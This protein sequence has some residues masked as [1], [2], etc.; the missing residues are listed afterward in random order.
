MPTGLEKVMVEVPFIKGQG[1]KSAP[2]MMEMDVPYRLHNV[3]LHKGSVPE[4]RCGH[5]AL[6]TST[7]G[8]PTFLATGIRRIVSVDDELIALTENAGTMG[9]GGGAGSSGDTV[10]AYAE[11]AD[12]WR[13]FGKIQR[14]TLDILYPIAQHRENVGKIDTAVHGRYMLSAEWDGVGPGIFVTITDLE[15]NTERFREVVGVSTGDRLIKCVATTTYLVLVWYNGFSGTFYIS[16]YVPSTLVATLHD[17]ALGSATGADNADVAVNADNIYVAYISSTTDV[18][19]ARMATGTGVVTGPVTVETYP[20]GSRVPPAIYIGS[21]ELAVVFG[22]PTTGEIKIRS[23]TDL[24]TLVFGPVATTVATN[25]LATAFRVLV[26]SSSIRLVFWQTEYDPSTETAYTGGN[27]EGSGTAESIY[28]ARVEGTVTTLA[29]SWGGAA[30]R[31]INLNFWGQPFLLDGRVF[32][33]VVMVRHHQPGGPVPSLGFYKGA[34]MT[35]VEHTISSAQA[36]LMPHAACML[37]VV[38]DELGR[39]TS[40]VSNKAYIASTRLRQDPGD[41][42]QRLMYFQHQQSLV[43]VFDFADDYRW[44]PAVHDHMVAFSGALPYVYDGK[45]THEC[46]FVARPEI[47]SYVEDTGGALTTG[48][49]YNYRVTWEYRDNEGRRWMSAPSLAIE[50]SGL[51]I[52]S[53]TELATAICVAG[54]SLNMMQDAS[55]YFPGKLYLVLWRATAE[56]MNSGVYVRETQVAFQPFDTGNITIV[57]EDADTD[58]DAAERLYI[59]GGELENYTAPPCRTLCQHRDRLFAYNTEW[60][61]LDYTKPMAAGRG[62]EWSLS[63]RIPCPEDIVAIESLEHVLIAFSKTRIYALEGG[64]PGSTGIPP[65]AFARLVIVNA[66]VGC[67]EVNAAWRCPAGIIFRSNG[68]FWL[69]DRS[70]SVSYIGAPIEADVDEM[71]ASAGGF[72]A[73]VGIVDEKNNCMRIYCD[74]TLTDILVEDEIYGFVRLNYWFDTGRWSVD[75]VHTSLVPNWACYHR[76]KNHH[77]A[78]GLG[79]V[80]EDTSVYADCGFF[81]PEVIQMGWA[82]FDGSA[83]F[84]RVWRTLLSFE[85]EASSESELKVVIHADFDTTAAIYN[86]TFTDSDIGSVGSKLL[87]IHMPRQKVRSLRVSLSELEGDD[88]NDAGFRFHGISFELGMKRGAFK[89]PAT[90][91]SR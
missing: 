48:G 90:S 42:N 45:T 43:C 88:G 4:K 53:G 18:L 13:A 37:D 3:H 44:K 59:I 82:R 70:M 36:T 39:N 31:S 8:T 20:S 17:F 38:G 81:Y 40:V 34:Y 5:T 71:V 15:S 63:Q 91:I 76:N 62:I 61:T 79:V 54:L 83:S 64:G 65:D 24:T 46:G 19:L 89:A 86:Q 78:N 87:R 32:L 49:E 12:K 23:T 57:S 11:T 7:D 52:N 56:Q 73:T 22:K 28:W 60:N 75:T 27:L 35:E 10:F 21:G 29:L 16:K 50:A 85:K 6:T 33:P 2:E 55:F 25:A 58:I 51:N 66:D 1:Q 30:R 41:P 14:P 80:Y 69:L 68:G 26:Y 77:I 74:A 9:S 47:I 84:K 67:C 72:S